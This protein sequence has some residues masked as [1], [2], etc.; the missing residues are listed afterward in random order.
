MEITHQE[1]VSIVVPV[2]NVEQYLNA[3]LN[4]LLTQTYRKIE[5]ILVDDGSTDKSG[6]ICNEYAEKD[7]RVK[8]YHKANGGVS[9]AR[10]YGIEKAAGTYLLFV[11]PDDQVHCQ[12]VE[13]FMN[14][15]VYG[16]VLLCDIVSDVDLLEKI[17]DR[18]KKIWTEKACAENFMQ[19]FQRDYINSPVNKLYKTELL[20]ENQIRFP[21]GKSLGEDLLFNLLY[22]RCASRKYRIIHAPL[23]YYRENR[24][25]SLSTFYRRDLFEIQQELFSE[26]KQFLQDMG[27]WNEES[28][29]IYYEMYWDRLYLSV[30]ICRAYEREHPEEKRLKYILN[31]PV[32]KSVRKECERRKLLNWK[33]RVKAAMLKIYQL[34]R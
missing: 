14:Q 30:R 5:I 10:N 11:D 20:R 26:L 7:Q 27:V 8:V 18:E 21:K 15:A 22:F 3:C 31:D 29:K 9:M 4:S 17:Y 28:E 23:Y 34:M 12:F 33:R 16:E 24:E 1:L 6:M 19:L 32:W 2:Y 25:G 13:L